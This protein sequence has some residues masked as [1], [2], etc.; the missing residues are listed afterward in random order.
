MSDVGGL[1]ACGNVDACS[2]SCD[3]FGLMLVSILGGVKGRSR[4]E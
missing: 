2:W 1:G 4:D 3:P